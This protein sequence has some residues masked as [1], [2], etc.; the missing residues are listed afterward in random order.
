MET[1]LNHLLLLASLSKANSEILRLITELSQKQLHNT[2]EYV[3]DSDSSLVSTKESDSFP[4][5]KTS[6]FVLRYSLLDKSFPH[7][8]SLIEAINDQSSQRA[9]SRAV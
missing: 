3:Q 6:F 9:D 5:I 1:R 8:A 2:P 4:E 7:K